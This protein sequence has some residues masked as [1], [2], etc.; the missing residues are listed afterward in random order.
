MH[1]VVV[2]LALLLSWSTPNALAENICLKYL[3]ELAQ[4]QSAF[5]QCSTLHSVPVNL[6]IG[7]KEQYTDMHATYMILREEKNCTEKFFDKDRINIVSTTQSILAGLWTKAY[8]DDCFTSNNW[9]VFDNKSKVFEKCLLEHKD[10]ECLV[11][12]SQYLDLNEFY[13][14]LDEKNNGNICYDLQDSMNRTR[15]HWSKDLG[16]C[17]REFDKL[18]FLVICGMVGFLP[19]L[20]YGTTFAL[21]KR[22]ERNHDILIED[23]HNSRP[24]RVNPSSSVADLPSTSSAATCPAVPLA[25]DQLKEEEFTNSDDSDF[26]ETANQLVSKKLNKNE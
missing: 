17:H 21:T 13:E 3:R 7:C 15:A 22:Q 12:L 18:L 4:N 1:Y 5:V 8:C 19:L 26:E 6:C 9:Q 25:S 14:S 23:P 16:C 24:T 20:F 2:F 10:N 11:C